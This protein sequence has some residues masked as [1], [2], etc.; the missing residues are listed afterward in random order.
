MNKTVKKFSIQELCFIKPPKVYGLR[1]VDYSDYAA[2]EAELA[3]VKSES[4]RV[5][6]V[7]EPCS[8][9]NVGDDGF[10]YYDDITGIYHEVIR[11]DGGNFLLIGGG[12]VDEIDPD[13]I[14]QPVELRRWEDE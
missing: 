3:R 2:L 7:G 8:I 12:C 11:T 1:F 9:D 14:V 4:L 6:E 5:V 10:L 13:A